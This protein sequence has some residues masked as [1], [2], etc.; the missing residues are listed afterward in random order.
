V[1]RSSGSNK[2]LEAKQRTHSTH[3][4]VTHRQP[5]RRLSH[6]LCHSTQV[7]SSL[8]TR[9]AHGIQQDWIPAILPAAI[10]LLRRE[11]ELR[12]HDQGVRNPVL[13]FDARTSLLPAIMCHGCL[14]IWLTQGSVMQ[15]TVNP[16]PGT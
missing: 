8:T 7:N 3:M 6:Q 1:H 4:R 14:Y 9:L 10:G 12:G 16:T 13:R 5:D 15:V 2:T 11:Y